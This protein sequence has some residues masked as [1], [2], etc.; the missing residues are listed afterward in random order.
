[1]LWL[2]LEQKNPHFSKHQLLILVLNLLVK[3]LL[4]A[5]FWVECLL[6]HFSFISPHSAQTLISPHSAQTPLHS[7][8][9]KPKPSKTTF[10][11]STKIPLLAKKE[12][13][14]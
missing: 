12:L 5:I 13:T 3:I 1:M 9:S 8:F 7:S 10:H 14:K 4:F 11:L 2:I 6:L